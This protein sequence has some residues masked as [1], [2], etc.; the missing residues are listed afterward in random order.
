MGASQ[1]GND[2]TNICGSGKTKRKSTYR[3][4][5]PAPILSAEQKVGR[6]PQCLSICTK[7]RVLIYRGRLGKSGN[8]DQPQRSKMAIA[9]SPDHRNRSHSRPLEMSGNTYPPKLGRLR[10]HGGKRGIRFRRVHLHFGTVA[11]VS[12]WRA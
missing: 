9:S 10:A 7:Q 2:C 6:A 12:S 4:T 3:Y 5:I 8:A 1:T 11:R